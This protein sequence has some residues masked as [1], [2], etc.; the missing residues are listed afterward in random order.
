MVNWK[1][2]TTDFIRKLRGT[3]SEEIDLVMQVDPPSEAR[4]PINVPH[5]GG[6]KGFIEP[7]EIG[8]FSNCPQVV[9]KFHWLSFQLNHESVGYSLVRIYEGSEYRRAQIVHFDTSSSAPNVIEQMLRLTTR[10]LANEG[11][12]RILG[13]ASG[14]S[15][16]EAF[17]QN[18]YLNSGPQPVFLWSQEKIDFSADNENYLTY[19]RGDDAIRPFSIMHN[20]GAI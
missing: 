12:L 20:S 10:F 18:G 8:W 3:G 2:K 14:G 19:L 17:E 4:V 16:G 11:A 1:T 13:R 6:L 15:M 7:W 5:A 9:G